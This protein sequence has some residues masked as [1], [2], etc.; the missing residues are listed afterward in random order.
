MMGGMLG[1]VGLGRVRLSLNIALL[2]RSRG[3][4][5]GSGSVFSL[6]A[7]IEECD[8]PVLGALAIRFAALGVAVCKIGL[9]MVGLAGTVGGAGL[10]DVLSGSFVVGKSDL[11]DT[12]ELFDAA[13]D[14]DDIFVS[15]VDT[16]VVGD[17]DDETE[18]L[19]SEDG[20]VV[21]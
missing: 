14:G 18:G 7:S 8:T 17:D 12:G 5:N 1:L 21:G 20:S 2:A 19:L 4:L 11:S 10:F 15:V 16:V 3:G 13:D 9:L 6:V